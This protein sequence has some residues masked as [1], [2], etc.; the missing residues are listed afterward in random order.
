MKWLDR[1]RRRGSHEEWL[2]AH[3]GKGA[4]TL[5]S[6]TESDAA[7]QKRT[8]ERMEKEMESDSA[9]TQARNAGDST[10]TSNRA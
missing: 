10:G 7:D 2:G 4:F 3:P 6:T 1:L 8:R 9:R 5:P